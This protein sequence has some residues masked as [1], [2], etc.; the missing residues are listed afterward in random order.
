MPPSIAR[1]DLRLVPPYRQM[2]I[3]RLEISGNCVCHRQPH[4][5]S[6]KPS[7]TGSVSLH[8][9]AHESNWMY[10]ILVLLT[11][12]NPVPC[13]HRYLRTL[14]P[15]PSPTPRIMSCQYRRRLLHPRTR[16]PA[17]G[18]TTPAMPIPPPPIRPSMEPISHFEVF[19]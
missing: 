6:V 3:W 4:C 7:S 19:W 12:I 10:D 15:P 2:I 16:S 9:M 18:L 11:T 13:P 1:I 14:T 8:H 17:P 5:R